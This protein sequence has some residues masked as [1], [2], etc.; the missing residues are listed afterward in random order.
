M[1]LEIGEVRLREL[2]VEIGGDQGLNVLAGGHN[3]LPA[4][5]PVL[6]EVD[7][8]LLGGIVVGVVGSDDAFAHE[9]T[10]EVVS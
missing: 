3:E 2:G 5:A 8:F 1:A 6:G 4:L 7:G 10:R 9:R